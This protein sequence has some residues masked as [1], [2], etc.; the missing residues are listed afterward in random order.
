MK[1]QEPQAFNPA[2]PKKQVW[3]EAFQALPMR[4]RTS[5]YDRGRRLL[6][7]KFDHT[8]F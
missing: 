7:V 3:D 4:S 2:L 8:S 6:Q 5:C 1:T